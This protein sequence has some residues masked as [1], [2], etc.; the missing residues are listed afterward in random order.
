MSK[1]FEVEGVGTAATVAPIRSTDASLE[2]A[3]VEEGGGGVVP[4]S[5]TLGCL[6]RNKE[7]TKMHIA[8]KE[9]CADER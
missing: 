7:R 5:L 8:P 9:W 3:S 2:V 6:E 4:E 1:S